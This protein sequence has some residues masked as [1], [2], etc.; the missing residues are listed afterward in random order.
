MWLKFILFL[1]FSFPRILF[2]FPSFLLSVPIVFLYISLYFLSSKEHTHIMAYVIDNWYGIEI[3]FEV[4]TA[5]RMTVV[6]FLSPT[7][8]SA[9][10]INL[11]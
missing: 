6:C 1:T 2:P 7:K 9:N 11:V 4:C 5:E 8:Q 10:A 3:N